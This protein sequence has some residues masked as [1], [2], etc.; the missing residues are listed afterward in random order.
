MPRARAHF[1]VKILKRCSLYFSKK[2]FFGDKKKTPYICP[3]PFIWLISIEEANRAKSDI[4]HSWHGGRESVL[5]K[6]PYFVNHPLM[7]CHFLLNSSKFMRKSPNMNYLLYICRAKWNHKKCLLLEKSPNLS[8]IRHGIATHNI[9][10]CLF[11]Y[12]GRR[13]AMP[14]SSMGGSPLL[15]WIVPVD[16]PGKDLMLKNFAVWK[17]F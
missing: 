8:S 13:L 15:F 9:V 5:K 1:Q 16:C 6:S 3:D 2:I 7:N 4:R 11:V 14:L 10:G 12:G 17:I